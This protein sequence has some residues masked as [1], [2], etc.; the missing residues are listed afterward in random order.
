MRSYGFA[1][2]AAVVV[3]VLFLA[4]FYDWRPLSCD[5]LL[6]LPGWVRDEA[7]CAG[8]T[9][10]T[11]HA[12]GIKFQERD[13]QGYF[14]MDPGIELSREE[15]AG[16]NMWMVWT[17]GNDR[18]WDEII[19]Y[20]YG[21][22]DLLKVVSSNPRGGFCTEAKESDSHY[23]DDA[24]SSVSEAYWAMH[25]KECMDAGGRW[26]P[27]SR[28]NRWAYYGLINEPCFVKATEPD[29]YGLWLDKRVPESRDCPADP[30]QSEVKYPGVKIGARGKTISVDSYYGRASGIV[31]LRLFSNPAFDEKAKEYW[32]K[33]M[34]ESGSADKY[35]NDPSFYTNKNLV[36]PYRIGM[37]CGFCH[38]GPSPINPPNNPEKPKWE[39][40]SSTVGA[41][42]LWLDR[43]SPGTRRTTKTSSTSSC[44]RRVLGL[45]IRRWS[46]ATISTILAP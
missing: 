24:Y 46:L 36:R 2:G 5:G 3:S 26:V 45:L 34:A 7:S 29:E 43:V 30:F 11:F 1:A 13:E 17:G 33:N 35:Y 18:F 38:V 16:R 27:I 22:F 31:G 15:S 32:V 4:L 19:K 42:Y 37:S 40:L 20:A 10:D 8:R 23:R 28:D 39:N 12:A 6:R 21:A 9:S 25:E 41:Q 14:K 44:T